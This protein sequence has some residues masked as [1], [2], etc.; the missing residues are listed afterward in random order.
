MRTQVTTLRDQMT[1]TDD[2]FASDGCEV[3]CEV[4]TT[5]ENY[6]WFFVHHRRH[7]GRTFACDS[8]NIDAFIP[9]VYIIETEEY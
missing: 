6:S 7:Y 4:T 2:M 1:T 5:A 8:V 3:F 9:L